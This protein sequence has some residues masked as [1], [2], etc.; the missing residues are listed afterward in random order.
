MLEDVS[1]LDAAAKTFTDR[2]L[3]RI[4]S[5]PSL[6]AAMNDVSLVDNDRLQINFF[7]LP[8]EVLAQVYRLIGVDGVK[9]FKF[10]REGQA[11]HGF[12]IP[13]ERELEDAPDGMS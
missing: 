13:L 11:F 12:E 2:L 10:E 5:S 9:L 6:L 1:G 3:L 7:R 8:D 4:H